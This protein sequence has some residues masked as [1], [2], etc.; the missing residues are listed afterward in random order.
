MKITQLQ[1]IIK[2]E[3]QN[4]INETALDEVAGK[5]F[6]NI[7]LKKYPKAVAKINQ[8]IDMIGENKF[9]MEMA[10]WIWDFFNNASYE[11]P[12]SEESLQEGV[13]NEAYAPVTDEIGS[14]YVVEAP[15]T[16]TSTIEDIMFECKDLAY[17][18]NQIRGGLKESDIKGI[19]KD[20]A[21][22]KALATK[23]LSN[24]TNELVFNDYDKWL[25]ALYKTHP[26]IKGKESKY[27]HKSQHHTSV[28]FGLQSFGS[29]YD[30]KAAVK[31]AIGKVYLPYD[32]SSH[33]YPT[34]SIKD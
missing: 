21:K 9:T 6:I 2:E 25:K 15:P 26:F 17:F 8:L 20:E 33:V 1:Q 4:V 34:N 3:I 18:A 31:G 5:Q 24:Q 19:F 11:S 23:L 27:F 13:I 29:W 12:I 7:K 16:K 30:G 32:V 10:E 28:N 14:F 22:A